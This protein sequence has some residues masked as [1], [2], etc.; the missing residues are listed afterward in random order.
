MQPA[1]KRLIHQEQ[2]YLD[3]NATTPMLPEVAQTLAECYASGPLNPASQHTVGRAARRILE[4]A[5]RRIV[6]LLGAETGSMDSDE[7]ILTSGGT[8]ANNLAIFGLVGGRDAPAGHI[9]VSGIEHD[10]IRRAVEYLSAKGWQVE[11]LGTDCHGLAKI[12]ELPLRIRPDTRLVSLM[13]ANNETGVLQPVAEAARVCRQF[14]IPL[15]TDGCQMVGKLPIHFRKLGVT[16]LSLAAHK[17]HGPAGMGGLLVRGGTHLVRDLFGGSQQQG[18]R[19]GTV[20]SA[21]A[22]GMCRALEAWHGEQTERLQRLTVLRDRFEQRIRVGWP[23]TVVVGGQSD[24][25][26]HTSNLAL[27]GLDR[28]QLLLALDRVGV[29]CSAGSACASGASEPSPTLIAMGCEAAIL[30]SALRFSLGVQTTEIE[31][32]EAT[33][34][35]LRVANDLWRRK[36]DRKLPTT[37]PVQ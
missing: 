10:S 4:T 2:I 35:I 14:A 18:L 20:S 1:M 37:P 32:D 13:L 12:K 25:L 29:A 8:E 28:Q 9:L 36:Q 27:V 34:R 30:E 33:C 7:L 17:F 11:Q 5:R 21:L 16:T 19:P 22:A 6:E 3:H 24:R 15:H 31:V 26:P 23:A